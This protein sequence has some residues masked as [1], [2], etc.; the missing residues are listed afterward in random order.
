MSEL[1]EA[2]S[3]GDLLRLEDALRRGLNP[4]EPDVEWSSRTPLH[5]ASAAGHKKCVF[6]LLQEGADPNAQTDYGWTAAH[7]ACEAGKCAL[8][9]L[10]RICAYPSPPTSFN[11]SSGHLHC[12]QTLLSFGCDL[13]MKDSC[14]DDPGTLAE[15]HGQLQCLALVQQKSNA[16]TVDSQEGTT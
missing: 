16:V 3:T 2:A 11:S 8:N 7:F 5:V 12:L 4:D 10:V 15:R 14:G 1:H 6:V 9:R 13:K